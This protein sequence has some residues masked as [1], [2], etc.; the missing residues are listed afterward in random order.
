[1]FTFLKQFF[2][3]NSIFLYHSSQSCYFF[4]SMTMLY[5]FFA[6]NFLVDFKLSLTLQKVYIML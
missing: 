1:M 4:S 5:N 3:F 2:F 6:L